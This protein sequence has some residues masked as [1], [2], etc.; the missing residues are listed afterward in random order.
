M[1]CHLPSMCTQKKK[2]KSDRKKKEKS[3]LLCDESRRV[4]VE[5]REQGRKEGKVWKVFLGGWGVNMPQ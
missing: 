2:K 1:V 4:G 3:Y 5:R